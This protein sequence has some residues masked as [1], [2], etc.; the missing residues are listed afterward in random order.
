MAPGVQLSAPYE[1]IG[2]PRETG[3]RRTNLSANPSFGVDAAGYTAG[4]GVTGVRVA[5]AGT[6]R[7][8]ALQLTRTASGSGAGWVTYA[9]TAAAAGRY[10]VS[11]YVSN[12]TGNAQAV[13]LGGLS[14]YAGASTVVAS[15]N[16]AANSTW[17]RLSMIVDIVGGDLVGSFALQDAAGTGTN[18]N[19]VYT[20]A[21]Q[22]ALL[23]AAST[24]V[25][26]FFDGT[27][28]GYYWTGTAHASTS[29]QDG[30]RAVLN[31]ET[32]PDFVGYVPED[33]IT[34]LAGA[35]SRESFVDNI[36][37]DGGVH[38]EFYQSR[39]PITATAF[40]GGNITTIARNARLTR[41]QQATRALRTRSVHHREGTMSW[42]TAGMTEEI[43][44]RFRRQQ[45][46]APTGLMAKTVPVGLVAAD[47]RF[48]TTEPER[49][50]LVGSGSGTAGRT[51]DRSYNLN[52]NWA[53]SRG[54]IQ[55]INLGDA[56]A[57][58]FISILAVTGTSATL[59][60][61][62]ETTAEEIALNGA[63]LVGERL[64]IDTYAKTVTHYTAA[65]TASNAFDRVQLDRTRWWGLA[66]GVNQINLLAG[67]M[68]ASLQMYLDWRHASA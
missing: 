33:G 36:E 15:A 42:Q 5:V 8:Y 60:V 59:A 28:P 19:V 52:F 10:V 34:G 17:T 58:V 62:N 40:I 32:D 4:A 54:I 31:T 64:E 25:P 47:P 45:A 21:W 55:P 30:T 53:P 1:F 11:A 24:F 26:K 23:E 6:L 65:G 29:A 18:T 51:Y 38:G 49:F 41:W 43:Y 67:T 61:Q 12:T 16:L 50:I 7:P 57:P 46:P 56:D 68:G 39:R 9:F 22:I 44:T 63:L 13:Q 27:S 48:Y 3:A 35:E 2:G 37:S 66:A 14:T 20:T